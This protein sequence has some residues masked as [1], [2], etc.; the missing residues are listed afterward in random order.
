MK[1]EFWLQRW[2]ENQIGFHLDE[3]NPHLIEYWLQLDIKPGGRVFV[4]L[5]GK[6]IDLNWLTEQGYFVEA[7]E[8][9]ES[10]IEQF[11]T[12]QAIDYQRRQQGDRI[13]FESERIRIWCGDFF[14]LT[15]EQLGS[16]DAIYDR[17]ALIALPPELRIKYVNHLMNIVGQVPQLLVTLDYPQQQMSG[18][19]F[20]VPET[21]V[22]NLY[23]DH[24][25]I[26][27]IS[28]NKA[29]ILSEHAH[30]VDRGLTSL[31]ECVYLM[32]VSRK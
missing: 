32:Q 2:K 14:H 19:P 9:S 28:T 5:C 1:P 22:F 8:L 13:V 25:D 27:T 4:P 24:T 17:A 3:V 23:R 18:P 6:S 20:S 29:D 11:F 30:F 21:E 12:E 26:D 31:F 16:I 15:A 7:V 10:A